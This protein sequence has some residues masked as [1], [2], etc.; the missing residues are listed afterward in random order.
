MERHEFL[1]RTAPIEGNGMRDLPPNIQGFPEPILDP[2]MEQA[3]HGNGCGCGGNEGCGDHR[4][5]G[6]ND[7]GGEH[8]GH[9]SG[10]EG[11]GENSWGLGGHPLA[12]VYASC[13]VFHSLYDPD[14][15][16]KRGTLFTELDLP[17][18]GAEGS[19]CGCR[20]SAERRRV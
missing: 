1:P 8:L 14:E 4:N 19:D 13:Q 20:C 15:A 11:C 10:H 5:D 12:M 16:L 2:R 9:C 18:G 7:H 17:F 6:C 3:L